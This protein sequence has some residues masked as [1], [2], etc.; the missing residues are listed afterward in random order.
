MKNKRVNTNVNTQNKSVDIIQNENDK[1]GDEIIADTSNILGELNLN[2]NNMV[3][4]TPKKK[5]NSSLYREVVFKY[6]KNKNE[7]G[8]LLQRVF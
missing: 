8:C 4:E 6:N 1:S 5:L 2:N 3:N 7:Y